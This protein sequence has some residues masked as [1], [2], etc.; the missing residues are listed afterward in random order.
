MKRTE[1]LA[2]ALRAARRIIVQDRKELLECV[3]PWPH[4]SL[5]ACDA[6]DLYW[7]RR[8]DRC[9]AKIDEALK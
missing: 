5:E 7:L 9:L 1:R 4:I 8:Y 6:D 2:K 3:T